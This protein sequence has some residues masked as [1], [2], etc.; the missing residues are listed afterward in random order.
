MAAGFD[1]R[2]L[3]AAQRE[4]VETIDGPLLILAGAGT[5][6][7]RTVTCRMAHLIDQGVRPTQIL[8]VT[9]TNKAA[10]EMQER[11]AGM[12][13]KSAAEELTVC[14]FH[15][16]CV[17]ILRHGIEK[18]DY[19][20]NYSICTPGDQQALVK[21]F[22]V[23]RGGL[24]EKIKP[25]EVLAVISKAKNDAN[26]FDSIEDDLFQ[27]IAVDYQNELRARN[28]VDFDDLLLLGEQLLR[29]FP[30]ERAYWQERFR[31][32]TVDE[33]QDTNS[34]Q[35]D[36]LQNLVGTPYNVCVVGDDDQ[37]IYG[38]RG[39]EVANIL[40]FERYFP[41]PAVVL[42]QDNY[43]SSQAILEVANKVIKN[44]AGRR[45]KELKSTIPGGDLIQLVSFPGDIEEAEWVADEIKRLRR[46][47]AKKLEGKKP[48][49]DA[50]VQ[51]MI[52]GGSGAVMEGGVEAANMRPYEDFSIL[53]RT[54]TQIRKMEQVLREKEIPY[55]VIGAQSFFDRREV[56]DVIAFLQVAMDPNADVPMLR[57]LNTPPR[58]ISQTTALLMNDWSRAQEQSIWHAMGDESF[59]SEL[60]TRS[61]NCIAEFRSLILGAH[62]RLEDGEDPREVLE[63]MLESCDYVDWLMRQSKSDTEKDGRRAGMSGLL[64]SLD[65]AVS[66]GKTVQR[67]LEET[68]LDPQ[69]EEELSD[70]KGVTLITLHAAK[71]LEFPVVFLVGL[72]E[73]I[74]PHKRSVEEGTVDE[75]RRLLY[76]GI[77]RAQER[78]S[79]TYCGKRVKWGEEIRCEPS[80]FISEL[81]FE[82][83]EEC[84]QEALMKEDADD[85]DLADFLG[86][87]RAMLD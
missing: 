39:A 3:N 83:I 61:K 86:G 28:A 5:G 44:N 32:V 30:D 41:D 42:L 40:Q 59:L 77:T 81:D 31:Y 56:R 7:T 12:V 48:E 17:R 80:S 85:E 20:K 84:D 50:A 69:N 34:L 53:F 33:F 4:A 29:E 76:V 37:S 2:Q 11:V 14:T 23:K 25:G 10:R 78:L 47:S 26:G 36:L 67:F 45:E 66:K 72:E 21:Q 9:F 8:A 63:S 64:D 1:I 74:L 24:K 27:A 38:W 51:R 79:L 75:E 68:L 6:K 54:N 55:R 35:M 58:G 49:V 18:L 62:V 43:R 46:L 71:G 82:W 22:I 70:K 65:R 57:I 19:K 87:M 15:S 60:S 52:G 16:L 13:S 73:G